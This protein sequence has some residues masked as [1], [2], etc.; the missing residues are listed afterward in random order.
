MVQ[1]IGK[2]RRGKGKEKAKRRGRKEDTRKSRI[3]ELK[4]LRSST[5]ERGQKNTSVKKISFKSKI[6]P[7]SITKSS[8]DID[9]SRLATST[10]AVSL[11]HHPL[12]LHDFTL[13]LLL[14]PLLLPIYS[15]KSPQPSRL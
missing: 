5:H 15:K 1:M 11:F 3:S 12:P 4:A 8:L 6:Y 10:L 9:Q 2:I 13:L 7:F 14:L